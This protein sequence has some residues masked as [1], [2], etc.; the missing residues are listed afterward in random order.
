MRKGR[1]RMTATA[2]AS[3]SSALDLPAL[4]RHLADEADFAD[5]TRRVAEGA[6][7]TIDGCWAAGKA[8]AV[9]ALA[10]G[11]TPLLLV[12]VPQ[13]ADPS[14]LVDDLR[15][16]G[17]S[18]PAT[19]PAAEDV[20][21][22]MGRES[23]G[24]PDESFGRRLAVLKALEGET[25][26]RL[27][28]TTMPALLQPVPSRDSIA[29]G[30]RVLKVGGAWSPEGLTDWLAGSGWQRMPAV[31]AP[32]EYAVRGG[33]VDVFPADADDP[34]RLEFFGDELESIREFAAASQRSLRTLDAVSLTALQGFGGAEAE[35]SERSH[36]ADL[37]PPGSV[38][39]LIEPQELREEARQY[40]HRL[41]DPRGL[42]A[43][44]VCWRRLLQFGNVAVTSLPAGG[45]DAAVSLRMESVERFSGN[46]ETL[47][48]EMDQI[49]GD[50][51]VTVV[52]HSG[53]D[54]DKTR[55]LLAGSAAAR[56]ERLAVTVAR[57]SGGFRWTDAPV[58]VVTDHELFRRRQV[59]RQSGSRRLKSRALDSFT[60]LHV[61]DVVVHAAHGIGIFRGM[62][63]I[64]KNDQLEEHLTLEYADALKVYVPASKI[65]LV[66]KYVGTTGSA[67]RLSKIGG[68]T[69]GKR[70]AAA[71]KAVEDFAS[72]LIDI[73]ASRA[74][75]SGFS[76]P[77]DTEWQRQFAASFPYVETPDQRA[78]IEDIRGDM[79]SP[80]PMDRLICGDV[81]FGKTELAMRAAFRA[82]DAGKQVAV[83]VPTTVL[84]QQ[85]LRTFRQ[86][87]AQFPFRIECV[88]R[89]EGRKHTREVL[90]DAAAGAVDILIGTHRLLSKDVSFADLGL[91]VV[92]EEQRFGVK[93]KEKLKAMR[94]MVDIL[95]LTATPIP[96]TLHSAL[97]G[98]R[99]ISNLTTPPPD[100]L[101][102]ETRTVRWD[103]E[104]VRHA[105]IRE[106][107]RGGQ[108]YFVHNR[109]KDI[110][111]VA[112]RLRR[113]VP[114]ASV[115]VAH[116]QQDEYE[117][118][119]AMNRFLDGHADVLVATTI[120]ESGIDIPTA[121]TMFIDEGD[122]YGLA[123]MHQ[124]RGRVGRGGVRAY[125]YVIVDEAKI[126]NPEAQRRLRAIEEF[127]DLGSG[128]QIA[129][130]DLEIRG[131]GNIL[132]TAQSGHIAAVGYDLYCHLLENAVRARKNLPLKSPLDV[133][134]ELPWQAYFPQ[135][136]VEGERHRIDAYRRLARLRN[137]DELAEFCAELVD[138]FGEPP[139]AVAN[140]L[141]LAELRILAHFWSVEAI[142]VEGDE[143]RGLVLTFRSP[144][145]YAL[146]QQSRRAKLNPMNRSD[147]FVTVPER[148]REISGLV[149]FLKDLLRPIDA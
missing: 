105:L 130:R 63:M 107:N 47:V 1:H 55:E 28:V 29:A 21:R 78:G 44:E 31:E 50:L 65:D 81:G 120:I 136:Y 30:S 133:T 101:P 116:G 144:K 77:I 127:T 146:L 132:G 92:D 53:A 138:R 41:D 103:D 113:I 62:K 98:I 124:L 20:A 106:L 52:C 72:E 83:L 71:E 91:I 56:E 134:V 93:H 95:T 114:E 96:R 60:D 137:A 139:Q 15:S 16:F 26:P 54:R 64:E 115:V 4:A 142:R 125:C 79:A 121:N 18:L 17:T 24:M 51:P 13:S 90:K 122:R 143:R 97:L 25:P 36:F 10:K 69:W 7:G 49:A 27:V 84:A 66:Q 12:V 67:P 111:K 86:R 74:G 32:G 59:T 9:A 141:Q 23:R 126:V 37:M 6:G 145:K 58:L 117:M 22:L 89:F 80:E 129:L 61:G 76:Y 70:K 112:D 35:R 39:A 43:P 100:R 38:V 118:A 40:V 87:M 75:R 135:N 11:Q 104:Q 57:L 2:V 46:V 33:I 8:L 3:P 42:Y 45:A 147:A 68:A 108:A 14:G 73:Q 110:H 148:Q 119:D 128:F 94:T 109:V 48:E 5:L 99:D 85:H 102:I 131:A 19:L 123:D 88:S 34:L 82:I 149:A 140:M